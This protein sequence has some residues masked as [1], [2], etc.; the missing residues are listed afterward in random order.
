MKGGK[1]TILRNNLYDE[2]N[3]FLSMSKNIHL[4]NK[5]MKQIKHYDF[6]LINGD[7]KNNVKITIYI[8]NNYNKIWTVMKNN[9]LMFIE[10]EITILDYISQ[11]EE[12]LLYFI[13]ENIIKLLENNGLVK[14]I[15]HK[16]MDNIIYYI[17]NNEKLNIN[18]KFINEKK[19]TDE[20]CNYIMGLYNKY[21]F[22][23]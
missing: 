19:I 20:M 4:K 13:K 12:L 8:D 6:I 21:M 11:S 9:N 10:H 22:Y 15:I 3:K 2:L 17:L 23:N 16:R 5:K 7:E 1:I 18:R 14:F